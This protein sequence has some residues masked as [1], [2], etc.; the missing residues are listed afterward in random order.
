MERTGLMVSGGFIEKK[1]KLAGRSVGVN[2]P[3]PKVMVACANPRSQPVKIRRG[4]PLGGLFNFFHRIHGR[5]V[6]D[7][8]A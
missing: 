8:P 3:F 5:K 7:D 1:I 4:E 2:L 6:F